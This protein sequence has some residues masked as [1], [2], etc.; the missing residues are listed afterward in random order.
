M[1]VL[2]DSTPY[3]I[4]DRDLL[5]LHL[6]MTTYKI[7]VYIEKNDTLPEKTVT[8]EIVHYEITRLS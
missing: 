3:P 5:P 8:C 4:K 2:D 1:S 6:D 7:I